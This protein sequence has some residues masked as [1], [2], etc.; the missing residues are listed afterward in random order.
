MTTNRLK[1]L[2]RGKVWHAPPLETAHLFATRSPHALQ[3]RIL[4]TENTCSA[5]CNGPAPPVTYIA[6]AQPIIFVLIMPN[7]EMPCGESESRGA[8]S[9]RL[10]RRSVSAL[11]PLISP[12]AAWFVVKQWGTPLHHICMFLI[13]CMEAEQLLM[14]TTIVA[15]VC[16]LWSV[17][18]VCIYRAMMMN[19]ESI[20][21]HCPSGL[22]TWVAQGSW[23][24]RK[25]GIVSRWCSSTYITYQVK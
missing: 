24:F 19:Q 3:L 11:V 4:S 9:C 20:D 18:S 2:M 12:C 7:F 16:R 6:A 13:A 25:N 10:E 23:S 21:T 22:P 8:S 1:G 15:A 14:Q 5:R 17:L